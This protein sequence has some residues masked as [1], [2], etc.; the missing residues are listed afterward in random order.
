ME[1]VKKEERKVDSVELVE[2]YLKDESYRDALIIQSDI[3]GLSRNFLH[4]KGF[5]E[6]LPVIVSTITDPLNKDVF[7]AQIDYYGY[8]YY[9]TKSMIVQKQVGILVHDKIF[10]FSPN[11]RLEREEKAQSGR[12]LIDFVQL[13]LEVKN[14][15]RND[16]MDLMEDLIIYVIKNI[17]QTYPNLIRKYHPTL[18]IPNKPFSKISVKEAKKI[19]GDDYERILSEK[20]TEPVWLIDM[21]IEE[22][23][24]YDKQNPFEP[25]TLLDFDLIYPEGFGESISGGEREYEYEQIVKRIKLKGNNLENYDDYLKIAKKGYLQP[26]AGCGIGIERFTRYILGLEHIEK[27]RLFAKIP[28]KFSI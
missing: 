17:I 13:D 20:A 25:D 1:I 11:L 15:K 19:Y 27:T 4:D 7:E 2:K 9:I 8:K 5:I 10:S 22:R 18:K 21:P 12:H 16:I 3:L 14:A 28:G 26:S 6:Y 23:E 24:F